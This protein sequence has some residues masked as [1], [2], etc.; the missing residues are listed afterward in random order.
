[1]YRRC[2]VTILAMDI[3]AAA[4]ARGA[5]YD[6]V[7][8]GSD[9]SPAVP[10][11]AENASFDLETQ[12]STTGDWK[13][14]VTAANDP[15]LEF[16]AEGD[17]SKSKICFVRAS[18]G[19]SECTFFRDLFSSRLTFQLSDGLSVVRLTSKPETKGLRLMATALYPTGQIRETAIWVYDE[20]RDQ[21]RV[22]ATLT[23]SEV[24]IFPSGALEGCLVTADWDRALE[25]SQTRFGSDHKRMITVYRYKTQGSAGSYQKVLTYITA[26]KYSPEDT[27]TIEAEQ[28]RI[29]EELQAAEEIRR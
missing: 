8:V 9:Q 10:E 29:K 17:P 16:E 5:A 18:T 21:F 23:S 27:D 7:A 19:T 15:N 24:R 3:A 1:M 11:Y 13:A 4:G 14:V 12:L 26:K 25:Q 2:L 22:A 6:A 20:R 28:V